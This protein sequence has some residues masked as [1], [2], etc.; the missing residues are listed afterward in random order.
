MTSGS[1]MTVTFPVRFTT[2]AYSIQGVYIGSRSDIGLGAIK[3]SST[4]FTFYVQGSGNRDVS[5]FAI[6]Y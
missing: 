2:T 4:K 5:W 6:G 3:N 1:N